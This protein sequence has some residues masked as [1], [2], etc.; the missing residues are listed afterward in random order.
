MRASAEVLGKGSYGTAYKAI[1]EDGT[2]VV[3]K[4][5]KDVVAGKKEFEQQMELIGR[6][7]KHANIAPIRAYYYSKDEKLVVYEYIATGSFSA[8]LHGMLLTFTVACSLLIYKSILLCKMYLVTILLINIVS[9]Y[10]VWI[11]SNDTSIFFIK[12]C[13]DNVTQ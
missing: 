7:G 5:L 13:F 3:V 6:V 4:R 9:R 2:S 1:L 8:L 12:V 11:Y 10:I